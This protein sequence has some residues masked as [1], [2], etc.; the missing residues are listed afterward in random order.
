MRPRRTS[1]RQETPQFGSSV[2][3]LEYWGVGDLALALP[4]LRAAGQRYRIT[5][6]VR[7]GNGA[8]VRRLAPGVEVVEAPVP[9]T[10]FHGKYRFWRWPWWRMFRVWRAM[11]AR[12]FAVGASARWDPRDP[13]VLWLMGAKLRIG[14]PRR[15]SERWLHVVPRD[16]PKVLHRREE[17]LGMAK[18]FGVEIQAADRFSGTESGRILVHSGAA[19]PIRVWPLERWLEV[20]RRL[21]ALGRDVR[22]LCDRAQ[23]DWWR[24]QG[25]DAVAPG[26]VDGLL[27]E[28]LAGDVFLGNDSGPGHLAA[29]SGIPTF[30]VFGPQL[31]E[32]FGPVHPQSAWV[33][34]AACEFKPCFDS[35]RFAEA[36]CLSD[37]A[38]ET[39][40]AKI[41][42][43]LGGLVQRSIPQ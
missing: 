28:I 8:A 12:R 5:V 15:G 21:R 42:T 1:K 7:T 34:G 39:T 38:L 23:E 16:R 29:V 30:T 18:V 4:F 6:V 27:D 41:R 20:V 9:W 25:E 40:W 31:P 2:L 43:W 37:V 35:C 13:A 22:V 11:R 3:L 14:Y 10:A 26:A 36:H 17:W 19:H 32:L 24:A 33:E